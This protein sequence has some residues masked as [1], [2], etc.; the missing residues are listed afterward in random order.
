MLYETDK[1]L[2]TV[3]ERAIN[4]TLNRLE[5]LKEDIKSANAQYD[6]TLDSSDLQ[7][8]C[9]IWGEIEACKQLIKQFEKEL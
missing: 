1:I 8:I 2:T 5:L 3:K 4:I 9:R 7:R 6:D